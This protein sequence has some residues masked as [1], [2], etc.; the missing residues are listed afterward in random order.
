MVRCCVRNTGFV[1]VELPKLTSLGFNQSSLS[2]IL[3]QLF[4][5]GCSMTA[6]L[7]QFFDVSEVLSH[8]RAQ[9][10]QDLSQF[11]GIPRGHSSLTQFPGLIL[12]F[13][14]PRF[15]QAWRSKLSRRSA[16]LSCATSCSCV[17]LQNAVAAIDFVCIVCNSAISARVGNRMPLAGLLRDRRFTKMTDAFGKAAVRLRTSTST[18]ESL[19]AK[20]CRCLWATIKKYNVT[21]KPLQ[22][23][24]YSI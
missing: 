4:P 18:P 19:L 2:R 11:I 15:S 5:P 14:T 1:V 21:V 7:S 12:R 8:Q 24:L 23:V 13:M 6:L 16:R 10:N 22:E 9:L 3:A 17:Q 20:L